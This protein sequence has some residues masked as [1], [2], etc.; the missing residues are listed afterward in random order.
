MARTFPLREQG[1]ILVYRATAGVAAATPLLLVS[2]QF[3]VLAKTGLSAER[4][5]S[6]T[7]YS[8]A[9]DGFCG[10]LRGFEELK[11]RL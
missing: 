10:V 7:R 11:L 4:P 9:L 1:A 8:A 3:S 6:T 2:L 5:R